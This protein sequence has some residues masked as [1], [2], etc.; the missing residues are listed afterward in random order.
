M[1]ANR[2][3]ILALIA[4][5]GAGSLAGCS[6][7]DGGGGDNGDDGSSGDSDGDAGNTG[8]NDGSDTGSDGGDSNED[9]GGSS[10]QSSETDDGGTS[11]D[12]G[13]DTDDSDDEMQPGVITGT[14]ESSVDQ[15]EV[16]SHEVKAV[17]PQVQV[18]VELRN[19]GNE[20][21]IALTHHNF[22]LE[23]FD[24]DGNAI[25]R[26]QGTRG[27]EENTDPDETGVVSVFLLPE[28]ETTPASYEIT[29]NCNTDPSMFNYCEGE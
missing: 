13:D 3:R 27:P 12:G 1:A 20:E 5:A 4:T 24:A 6:G 25:L 26:D 15:L 14:A 10:G 7:G 8:E 19:A 23:L 16:V 29:V 22:A 21:N 9:N 17:D 18:D 28:P 11:D 2:R